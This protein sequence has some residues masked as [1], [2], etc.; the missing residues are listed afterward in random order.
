MPKKLQ[1]RIQNK[2]DTTANWANNYTFKP[3]DGEIIILHEPTTNSYTLKV[4]N[5][6]DWI[7]TLPR[8]EAD[9]YS[10]QSYI[11]NCGQ[12]PSTFYI[13]DIPYLFDE[14]MNWESWTNS[15]YC[16]ASGLIAKN[17]LYRISEYGTYI[18]NVNK[19]KPVQFNNIDVLGIDKIVEN[20]YYFVK[21]GGAGEPT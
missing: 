18:I 15:D 12:A 17:P 16:P 8:I 5:D 1:V 14:G 9:L 19:G 13:D 20:N 2:K 4:G 21:T 6:K 3:L 10:G 7:N 11:F